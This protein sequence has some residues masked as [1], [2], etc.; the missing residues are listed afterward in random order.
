[1][2]SDHSAAL[3]SLLAGV[4]DF[5]GPAVAYVDATTLTLAVPPGRGAQVAALFVEQ[6]EAELPHLTPVVVGVGPEVWS[7][8][9]VDG[10]AAEASVRPVGGAGWQQLQE[11]RTRDDAVI[12][13]G[14]GREEQISRSYAAL[15]RQAATDGLPVAPFHTGRELGLVVQSHPAVAESLADLIRRHLP[16]L[17][18]STDAFADTV[19]NKPHGQLTVAENLVGLSVFVVNDAEFARLGQSTDAEGFVPIGALQEV[20]AARAAQPSVT[21]APRVEGRPTR[22]LHH[23]AARPANGSAAL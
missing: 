21:P 20:V 6:A 2:T 7:T 15:L 16:T 9:A 5:A 12:L 1:M 3:T 13:A 17:A 4:R 23:G 18:S 11:A 8:I 14:V 22:S 19:A 10:I